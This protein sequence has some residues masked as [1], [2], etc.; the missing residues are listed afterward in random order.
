MFVVKLAPMPCRVA[1]RQAGLRGRAN[2]SDCTSAYLKLLHNP[3]KTAASPRVHAA[4]GHASLF[5][6]HRSKGMSG[7]HDGA[8]LQTM[9]NV[10][11]VQN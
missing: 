4:E 3:R 1:G 10:K 5:G 6:V 11:H 8:A 9:S 2:N 7:L